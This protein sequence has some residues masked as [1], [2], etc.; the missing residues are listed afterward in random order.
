M[1]ILAIGLPFL[2]RG[3]LAHPHLHEG[4]AVIKLIHKSSLYKL[5]QQE[6]TADHL[7]VVFKILTA[8]WLLLRQYSV[9]TLIDS[10]VD[11]AGQFFHISDIRSSGGL[12]WF[13]WF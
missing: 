9:F 6:G 12:L 10:D 13:C 4:R 2:A 8:A 11:S 7:A 3:R 5:N 1:I